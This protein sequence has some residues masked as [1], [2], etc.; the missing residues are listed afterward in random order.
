MYSRMEPLMSDAGSTHAKTHLTITVQRA[1]EEPA[2]DD[3]YRVLVD[4]LWPRGLSR[5]TL[6]L[7][8]WAHKLAPSNELRKWF[9]HDPSLWED[10]QQRYRTELAAE[11][12]LQQLQ[13]LLT[14]ANGRPIVLVYGAKDEQHNQ[15]IV[16][17][18]VLSHLHP[19]STR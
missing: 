10:F 6:K 14:E 5:D 12:K 16:L 7:D 1:Y 13:L 18:D 4:R 9:G 11:D 19:P 15:A 17:R 8:Q 3:S 2:D